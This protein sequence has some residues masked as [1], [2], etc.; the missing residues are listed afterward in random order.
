VSYLN[1]IDN[2]V[3]D[4][5]SLL[6]QELAH[7][8]NVVACCI[9]RS[10]GHKDDN[11]FEILLVI[12]HYKV[13]VKYNYIPID[14]AQ[15]AILAVDKA[16]FESDV[17]EASLGEFA[18]SRLLIPY[19]PIINPSYLVHA[20]ISLK[21][22]TILES[23]ENIILRYLET[24]TELL[25]KPEYFMHQNVSE[26]VRIY[27]L[28]KNSYLNAFRKD[29]KT[30][31]VRKIMEGYTTAL[32]QLAE[33]N[34][35]EFKDDFIKITEDF[36]KAVLKK[37]IGILNVINLLGR[38]AKSYIVH[39]YTGQ[40]SPLIAAQEIFSKFIIY[41]EAVNTPLETL[42]DPEKYIFVST[43]LGVTS[44]KFSGTIESILEKFE[45]KPV[46]NMRYKK[47]GGVLNYVYEIDYNCNGKVRKLVAKNFADWYGLK[48]F[49]LAI[50]TLGITDFDITAKGRM[51]NEFSINRFLKGHGFDVPD[52]IYLDWEKSVIVRN[53][54]DGK[55]LD[56][57]I[58]SQEE[59][60]SPEVSKNV[61]QAGEKIAQVHKSGVTLG[62]CKDENLISNDGRIFFFDLE[63]AHKH[64][65]QSWD[66][67]EF[68]YYSGRFL[69][70]TNKIHDIAENF[71]EGYLSVGDKENVKRISSTVFSSIF[72]PI[73][74]IPV[75]NEITKVCNKL[76]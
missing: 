43:D 10:S 16:L 30:E 6:C 31:N 56:I 29:L 46:Q 67:A 61:F 64:G 70:S 44:L 40:I 50:W 26:R 32:Q 22:R 59:Q 62:D 37:K 45:G 38:A 76:V 15:L 60:L 41:P 52:I 57:L 55:T 49:P 73:T 7:P 24:A 74:P 5:I 36:I 13:G 35:I 23:L 69:L 1:Q 9:N 14:S 20:E 4:K 39:G 3:K 65:H 42:E 75:V 48:W 11:G 33:E 66:I 58:R 19:E 47:I 53:F 25:I 34:V 27:P 71:L 8:S 63:Q 68:L 21:K 18:T 12:E 51:A 28:D 72:L 17:N 2:S 54:V